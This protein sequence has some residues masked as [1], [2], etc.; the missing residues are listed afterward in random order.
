MHAG[1]FVEG[2]REGFVAGVVRFDEGPQ[3]SFI[4]GVGYDRST[5]T[6]LVRI[7]AHSCGYQVRQASLNHVRASTDPGKA[8]DVLVKGRRRAEVDSC[9][10]C[11]RF[12]AA[13]IKHRCPSKHQAPA[14]RTTRSTVP[15]GIGPARSPEGSRLVGDRR[16]S[17]SRCDEDTATTI[18]GFVLPDGLAALPRRVSATMSPRGVEADAC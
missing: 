1:D 5:E 11:P 3:S 6:M 4:S 12:L 9:P 16:W 7:G 15:P 14:P 10:K 13:G 18:R 2:C 17:L 8:Y